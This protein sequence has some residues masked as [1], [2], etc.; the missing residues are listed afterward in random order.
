MS[1]FTKANATAVAGLA[2]AHGEAGTITTEALSTAFGTT[3]TLTLRNSAILPG[4]QVLVSIA[5]GTNSQGQPSLDTV[6]AAEG[7]ATI[8]VRNRDGAAAFNGTL[9]IS[10]L[11]IN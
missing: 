1:Y 9:K 2:T 11:V 3:Y 10:Y 7:V 4:A 8:V 5:N 6:A